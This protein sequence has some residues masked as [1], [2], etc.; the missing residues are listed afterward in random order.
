MGAGW[1]GKV[2]NWSKESQT[3]VVSMIK[4]GGAGNE[5]PKAHKLE[6][7]KPIKMPPVNNKM[8]LGERRRIA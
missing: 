7:T 5:H 1:G 2:R 6:I 3:D 4:D 8:D